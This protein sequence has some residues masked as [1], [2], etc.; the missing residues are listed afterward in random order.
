MKVVLL[1]IQ[2]DE[3]DFGGDSK[4]WVKSKAPQLFAGDPKVEYPSF[5]WRINGVCN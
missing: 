3:A 2:R 4:A 5:D 1:D